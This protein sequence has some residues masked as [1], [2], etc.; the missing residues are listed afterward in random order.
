MEKMIGGA[1]ARVFRADRA[2]FNNQFARAKLAMPQLD[3]QAFAALLREALQPV[4][5]ALEEFAPARTGPA[6]DF[7]FDT[8]LGFVGKGFTRRYPR[9]VQGWK[10]LL[11]TFPALLGEDPRRFSS[12]VGNAL[13]NLSIGEGARPTE[14]VETMFFAGGECANLSEFLEAGKV[15]AW[16][17]GLAHY[18]RSA[19][20]ACSRLPL[21]AAI[22]VL[23]LPRT[24]EETALA[25]TL[26]NLQADP[27]HPIAPAPPET[28]KKLKI[29]A[30]AGSFRGFGGVI[31]W[32]P[33]VA[34]DGEEFLVFDGTDCWTLSADRFGAT[35]QRTS[36]PAGGQV[37]AG[38]QSGAIDARGWVAFHGLRQQFPELAKS[39]SS[40]VSGPTLAVSVPYS[41][42]VFLVAA[43]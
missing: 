41:H 13:Y 32:P 34:P 4:A 5:E 3:E 14:W 8:A 7:L 2:R 28:E 24:T 19:L 43:T 20:E 42:S 39:T 23:G 26:R 1:L 40:A 12:S 37:A 9:L 29:V 10:I 21:K 25:A 22:A 18:R 11:S 6:I 38:G 16:L 17:C 36:P 27:W 30:R 15:A 33:L 35:F 31:A